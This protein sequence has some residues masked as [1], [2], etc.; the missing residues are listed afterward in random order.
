MEVNLLLIPIGYL[1]I[2][3]PCSGI[4]GSSVAEQIVKKK[5]PTAV[6]LIFFYQ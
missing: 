3:T 2:Q 1:K 4:S 5:Q 6:F